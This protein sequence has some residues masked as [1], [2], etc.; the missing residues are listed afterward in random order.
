MNMSR[1]LILSFL[2]ALGGLSMAEEDTPLSQLE[3][4][5][6]PKREVGQPA[7]LKAH[8]E[9]DGRGVVIA[10]FDTGV[11]PAAAGLAVTTTG[12]RKILDI[13]DASGSGDV[14][15]RSSAKPDEEGRITG[16]SGKQLKLPGGIT[17]PEGTFRLGLK[18]AADIFPG[19]VLRRLMDHEAGIWKAGLSQK[20]AERSREKQSEDRA[21]EKK[22]PEDQTREEQD[23]AAREALLEELED[24][25]LKD[26]PDMH[27]DCVVWND[28][29]HWRV[30][31]DTDRDADLADET[32]LR[33]FG[34]AGEYA[35][36]DPVS[37]LSFGVQVYEEGDL[38]TIVT[39]N[40]G[41][42]TH[43]ASMA[44]AY[45]PDN[46]NRNGIAP[47]AQ[48]VSIRLGDPRTGGSYG[49][50]ERRAIAL[51]AQAGVDIVNASWGGGS[52][53][54]DGLDANSQ[55]YDMLA[56]RYG[57]L[58][59]VSAGNNGPALS[60]LGSAGG[61]ARR[62]LGVGAYV[63]PEMGK[64]LYS[65]L[66]ARE[67]GDLHFTSRGPSK[68]GDWGVDVIAPGAAFASYSGE[69]MRGFEMAN[70]TSMSAP[71]ASGVAA[72]LMSGAKQEGL[73]MDPARMRAAMRLGARQIE[74]EKI[75][76]QGAGLIQVPGAWEQLQAI[77]DEPAFGAFF[78]LHVTG[79]S[80]V[81]EGRGLYVRERD[82]DARIRAIVRVEPGWI[83]A[84]S[85][86][87]KVDFEAAFTLEATADWIEVPEFFHL[88]NGGNHFIAHVTLPE[89]THTSGSVTTAEIQARL[90]GR[91]DLGP[92]FTVPVTIVHGM[93]VANDLD[94]PVLKTLA[95]TPGETHR[96]FLHVPEGADLLHLDLRHEGA[97][98]FSRRFIVYGFTLAPELPVYASGQA[99]HMRL[100]QGEER[101]LQLSTVG[102][103]VMELSITQYWT[104]LTP[105]E[106]QLELQW[107]G[108]GLAEGAG[109]SFT[110]NQGWATLAYA[111]LRD[112]TVEISAALEHAVHVFMPVVAERLPF[113]IRADL[114]AS[115]DRPEPLRQ[116]RVRQ[117]FELNFEEPFKADIVYP[118]T[119][120]ISEFFGGGFTE[121]YHESGELL[122]SG[123]SWG[124]MPVE[125]PKGKSYVIRHYNQVKGEKLD[126]TRAF[127]L[128]LSRSLDGAACLPVYANLR[129]RFTGSPGSSFDLKAGQPGQLFLQDGALP[130]LQE[131]KP[132]PDH[133]T[134]EVSF[135]TAEGGDLGTAPVLYLSGTPLEDAL[136]KDP[137]AKPAEDPRTP[138]ERLADTLFEERLAFVRD[139]RSSEEAELQDAVMAVV[140]SL[141]EERPDDPV[142]V[143]EKALLLAA[144]AGLAGDWWNVRSVEEA[145]PDECEAI[146]DLLGRARELAD[147]DTVAGFLGAPPKAAP[148]DLEARHRIDQQTKEM[149]EAR[150]V[151]LNINH[152]KA[153]LMR[154]TDKIDLSW[155]AL[156]QASRWESSPSETTLAI[157][158]A[159]YE[160]EGFHGLALKALNKQLEEDPMN[161]ELLEKQIALYEKLGWTTFAE[162]LATR[163]AIRAAYQEKLKDVQ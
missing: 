150:S 135:K 111:S 91:E 129:A 95:M 33:P 2:I 8:P 86:R 11:D 131:M 76:T 142:P 32:I 123:A 24:A 75:H 106:L 44:A 65:T 92:V 115:P 26:L 4:A 146:E 63:S 5:F 45:D 66:Q 125:F 43:V 39:V 149:E 52:V 71:V 74:N 83:E 132:R 47:G 60:T 61:E 114:P 153:D 31:V 107:S 124:Q 82:P 96:L 89:S 137:E 53:Y 7:F 51:A 30:L 156:Q 15:T 147:P 73:R 21:F 79:G 109:L 48:I 28:G 49:T 23:L 90:I 98:S 57:I 143:F 119:Y 64:V 36:F 27:F 13:I 38:L 120:D 104:D 1:Y 59:V 105:T 84:V 16:L 12:E 19:H 10:V 116:E 139:N 17:N 18:R 103:Q 46:P 138:A 68:D 6:I 101:S 40:G 77:Q 81:E 14:D 127:P 80:F 144:N 100:E 37:N 141:M 54:Q 93:P 134:G 34:I 94:E 3:S 70:G 56:E 122:F 67:E 161:K 41:H 152:L 88:A 133:F 140:E 154:A 151:L 130:S 99:N 20:R 25:Y 145:R 128:V 136:R 102:G 85:A 87:E 50:S 35:I 110:R 58:P 155:E 62:V 163:L 22:A 78:D 108:L 157:Q 9:A 162:A 159:L 29:E 118:Q 121:A 158:S 126:E 148:G 97:D 55:G 69:A 160:A 117:V 113:D 42:G 112:Q 72:L